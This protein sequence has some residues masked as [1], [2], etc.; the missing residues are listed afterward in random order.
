MINLHAPADERLN[1]R[2]AKKT[3]RIIH[4][5]HS[6][7]AARPEASEVTNFLSFQN[8][9]ERELRQ[10]QET[11]VI[12]S[13][14]VAAK[15][16][17]LPL[18]KSEIEKIRSEILVLHQR[19]GTLSLGFASAQKGEG[20]STI[21]ANLVADL[22]RTDLR[23]LLV[24]ANVQH[25]DLPG[26][27]SLQSK[28]GLVDLIDGHRNLANVMQVLKPNKIFVL[29]LGQP[30]KTTEFEL[31]P[32]LRAINSAGKSSRYF[33]LILFDL[34]PLHEVSRAIYAARHIDGV[35]Q[36]VQAERTR[37]EVIKALKRKLDHVGVHLFGVIL[38][39]RRFHIPGFIYGQ[40]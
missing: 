32:A 18:A 34:P 23:I 11:A 36:V 28:R 35:I 37:V 33:D 5:D 16:R 13:D 30:K 17:A 9:A 40:L 7:E 15:F 14:E 29:P 6:P 3:R 25:P 1:G 31:E 19:H 2:A 38:N 8:T 27:F 21:L 39:Q 10:Q 22:R 20:T 24:D 12:L 26:L 4:D